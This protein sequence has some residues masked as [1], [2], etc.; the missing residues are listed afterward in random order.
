MLT[1]MNQWPG[2]ESEPMIGVPG[3]VGRFR[4]EQIAQR[5]TW[6][7]I[8]DQDK[9]FASMHVVHVTPANG[10]TECRVNPVDPGDGFYVDPGDSSSWGTVVPAGRMRY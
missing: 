1:R 6:G 3:M 2:Q 5:S 4:P 10:S 7:K 8:P 9:V